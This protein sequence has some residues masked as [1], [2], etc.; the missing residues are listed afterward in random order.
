MIKGPIYLYVVQ[1]VSFKETDPDD[2]EDIKQLKVTLEEAKEKV[3]GN[4]ITQGPS[5]V[6]ILKTY[7]QK[8]RFIRS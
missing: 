6:L 1:N 4:E 2:T 5:C 3:L 7:L 8:H